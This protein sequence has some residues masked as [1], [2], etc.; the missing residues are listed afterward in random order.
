LGTVITTSR[1]LPH[2][3]NEKQGVA[4]ALMVLDVDA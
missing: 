1:D 3:S 2:E 4:M